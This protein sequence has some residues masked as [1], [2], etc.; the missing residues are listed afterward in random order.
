MQRRFRELNIAAEIVGIED[1]LYVLQAVSGKGRDLQ[2]RRRSR[3][4]TNSPADRAATSRVR[5]STG[6]GMYAPVCH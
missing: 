4:L 1:R 6:C 2:R 3:G 5:I